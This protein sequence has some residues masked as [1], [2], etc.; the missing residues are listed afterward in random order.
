MADTSSS[1][2]PASTAAEVALKGGS[3]IRSIRRWVFD[4][5][6]E[7]NS[8][9]KWASNQ[10]M[11][12][13]GD[14]QEAFLAKVEQE[15]PDILVSTMSAT[16]S[17]LSYWKESGEVD[18]P[19]HSVVTDFASHQMWAQ[20]NIG[21]YY[22]AAPEVEADLVK[23]HMDSSRVVVT[24]IPINEQ[25][26]APPR[27]SAEAKKELG[28][29]PTK[30]LVLMM[31][32]SLGYGSFG[33]SLTALDETPGN[34]QMAAIT[35]KNEKLRAELES[36]ETE[37]NLSVQGYVKNMPTWLEAADIVVTKP[38]GLTCSEI[39]ARGKP[40]ILHHSDSGLEGRLVKRLAETGAAVV[41]NDQK[42]LSET[43]SMLFQD[44]QKLES[45]RT[46][47]RQV[48][49]PNSSQTI[50]EHIICSID[51]VNVSVTTSP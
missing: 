8:L 20:E 27:E 31:G 46:K 10:A 30:P 5:Q 29:D 40:M 3:W 1:K 39:L 25:F 34:F 6:Y 21:Y 36:L 11:K 24:G 12:W 32:G 35:G 16:N 50:A 7:G 48:G 51:P 19:V 49:K 33:E 18:V 28:L 17:L 38:G 47:A 45:L 13:E 37:R 2:S 26:A 15:Q 9:I 22:V 4:Q 23:F 14:S 42:E 44:P 43:V 41:V